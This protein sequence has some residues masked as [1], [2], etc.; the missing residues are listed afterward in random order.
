MSDEHR[1]L[2]C[3]PDLYRDY[4]LS[5]KSLLQ[6]PLYADCQYRIGQS[7]WDMAH[8]LPVCVET[9][10]AQLVEAG[11]ASEEIS[12]LARMNEAFMQAMT[13][14]VLDV[15]VARVGCDGGCGQQQPAPKETVKTQNS[16]KKKAHS[17][18]RA[19]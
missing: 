18:T 8:E 5:L 4:W 12:S 6:S 15:T 16:R 14:L 19:A 1:A 3:W 13:G 17:P 11:M 2:A 9:G 10:V 7:A